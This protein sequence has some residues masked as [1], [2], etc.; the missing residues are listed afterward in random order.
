MTSLRARLFGILV[1][2]TGALWLGAALW[3]SAGAREEVQQV[4]DS[5]LREA[6]HMVGTLVTREQIAVAADGALGEAAELAF[7]GPDYLD[8]KLSC[9]SWSLRGRLLAKSGSAPGERL[10]DHGDG[11]GEKWIDGELWRVYALDVPE[12]GVR[13]LIG[14]SV[15]RRDRLVDDI[16]AGLFVPAVPTLLVLAGVLWVSV[17][18]GLAPLDRLAGELAMRDADDL[19]PVDEAGTARELRPV[20]AALNALFGRV[21][22]ARERE[23]ER[24]FTDVAAHELRTPIAGLRTQPQVALGANDDETRRSALRQIVKAADRTS[25]LTRQLL[26]L[27]RLEAEA[28]PAMREPVAL[29]ALLARLARELEASRGAATSIILAPALAGCRVASDPR[30]LEIALRN[31]LENA[32][33]HS[34]ADAPVRCR[35]AAGE[36]PAVLVEDEGPGVE[37]ADLAKLTRRFL[38]GRARRHRQRSGARDRGPRL[39]PA[40]RRAAAGEPREPGL[41]RRCGAARERVRRRR[42]KAALR[43]T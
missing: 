38:R 15:A 16:M 7:P 6:A 42:P 14:D 37:P 5:R 18:R 25:R 4:L 11:F 28:A 20:L 29:D 33:A 9:Q 3:I 10:A 36:R 39:P 43:L 8:K 41:S 30:L 34:P 12:T 22:R 2:A 13:I 35:L 17:R 21:E 26:A 31:L 23:R 24:E 40:R 27:S 1:V 19:R 32:L